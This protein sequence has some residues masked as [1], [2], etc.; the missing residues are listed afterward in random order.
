MTLT[1]AVPAQVCSLKRDTPQIIQPGSPYQIVRFPFGSLES[2]DNH[3]MHQVETTDYTIATW[4]SDERSG[5]IWPARPGWGHLYAM[6]QWEGGNY[7]ELRD[8][9]VRDPLGYG[10]DPNNTTATDHRPPSPGM[11]CFTKSHGVFVDPNVPL[12]LRATH[13]DKVA[14]AITLAEFK[15]VIYDA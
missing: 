3:E 11:Q 12:A 6:I 2:T 15:L 8:Q 1:P 13:N 10:S 9:F 14:R 7:T 4:D 5:L